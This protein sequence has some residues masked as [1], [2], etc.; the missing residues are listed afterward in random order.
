MTASKAGT[1]PMASLTVTSDHVE[2]PALIAVHQ[3][4]QWAH[5]SDRIGC[6]SGRNALTNSFA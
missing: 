2:L 3:F 4:E 1:A 6:G 5:I